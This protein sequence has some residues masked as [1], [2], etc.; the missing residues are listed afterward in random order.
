MIP[1]EDRLLSGAPYLPNQ[2]SLLPVDCIVNGPHIYQNT[3]A[4]IAK[5]ASM[6]VEIAF[7]SGT[8]HPYYQCS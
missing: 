1:L 5:I 6:V 4:R 3:D 7:P 8:V 2:A